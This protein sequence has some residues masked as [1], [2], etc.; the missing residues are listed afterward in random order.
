MKKLILIFSL[1]MAVF[2]TAQ[3]QWVNLTDNTS[4][5]FVA[6]GGT[7]VSVNEVLFPVVDLQDY[8]ADNDTLTFAI[9]QH[10]TFLTTTDSLV[11]NTLLML[12]I[13][14]Q[15]DPGSLLYI[16]LKSGDNAYSCTPGDGITGIAISGASGKTKLAA[17]IYDG[18]KFIHLSTQQIN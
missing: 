14:S 17:Y 11:V 16:E 1:L 2:M 5:N 10:V 18:N 6:P 9:T 15:V 12:D 7:D 4:F 13:H 3:A 8:T